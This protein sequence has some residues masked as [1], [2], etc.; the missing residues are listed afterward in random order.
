MFCIYLSI[1][2]GIGTSGIGKAMELLHI[3]LRSR[4]VSA[5][6]WFSWCAVQPCAATRFLRPDGLCARC[7]RLV[8][9]ISIQVGEWNGWMGEEQAC[10]QPLSR[11]SQ[12]VRSS[13]HRP[14]WRDHI[15]SM[16]TLALGCLERWRAEHL[17]PW[18][19]SAILRCIVSAGA[20]SRAGGLTAEQSRACK[21]PR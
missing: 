20:P 15:I 12:P 6:T 16:L 2:L 19:A 13:D 18:Q 8:S 7:V 14:P 10:V 11:S 4:S 1:Y 3:I 5:W 17:V 21:A 9:L